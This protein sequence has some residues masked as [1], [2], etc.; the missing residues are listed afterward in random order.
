[1]IQRTP[2]GRVTTDL[3]YKHLGLQPPGAIADG[4]LDL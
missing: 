2:R 1:M 4:T 3:A